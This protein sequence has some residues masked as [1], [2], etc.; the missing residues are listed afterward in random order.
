MWNGVWKKKKGGK[1]V[2]WDK[3]IA[4]YHP[5]KF[6]S[7]RFNSQKEQ[8]YQEKDGK[9]DEPMI[10][11]FIYTGD[12]YQRGGMHHAV[13]RK[14]EQKNLEGEEIEGRRG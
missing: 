9:Y 12:V 5:F 10:H 3:T 14:T 7:D 2:L 6:G 13:M 4:D 1:S 11:F 8:A